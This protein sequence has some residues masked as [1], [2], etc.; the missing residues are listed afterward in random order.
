[1]NVISCPEFVNSLGLGLD[2]VGVV[3]LFVFGLPD[4]DARK[5]GETTLRT[6]ADE[7]SAIKWRRYKNLS[8]VALGFLVVGFGLQII[9][10]LL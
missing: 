5:T 2:I 10:N 6:G 8:Y 3:L 4:A 9:S 1:M 7:R